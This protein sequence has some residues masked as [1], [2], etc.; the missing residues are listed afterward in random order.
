[1]TY[2]ISQVLDA[3]KKLGGSGGVAI[4]ICPANA[5]TEECILKEPPERLGGISAET[6]IEYLSLNADWDEIRKSR[7]RKLQECDWTALNDI[8]LDENI[9]NAW[10]QYRQELRDITKQADPTNITWPIPPS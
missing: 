8:S 4:D 1:M 7:D 10:K 3:V 6:I 9:K 2:N 5:I